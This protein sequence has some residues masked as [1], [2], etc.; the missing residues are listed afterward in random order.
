MSFRFLVFDGSRRAIFKLLVSVSGKVF[1]T[2]GMSENV[3]ISK[4][5]SG[6][7]MHLFNNLYLLNK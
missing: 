2:M 5:N 7:A 3:K 6:E 4:P 1:F